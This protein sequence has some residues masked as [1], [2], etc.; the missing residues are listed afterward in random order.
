QIAMVDVRNLC[1]RRCY[2]IGHWGSCLLH[3]LIGNRTLLF[4]RSGCCLSRYLRTAG[5]AEL[6]YVSH[7]AATTKLSDAKLSDH[8][9]SSGLP[10]EVTA[11]SI[12]ESH[13]T[14]ILQSI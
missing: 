13:P 7:A 12:L 5:R 4:H 9:R 10:G 14:T 6:R 1:V 3:R 8:A 2:F 11:T